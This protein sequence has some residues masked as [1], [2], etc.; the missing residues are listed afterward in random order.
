MLFTARLSMLIMHLLPK[1]GVGVQYWDNMYQYR[2]LPRTTL[3]Q[4]LFHNVR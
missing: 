2:S 4:R 3:L 1:Q